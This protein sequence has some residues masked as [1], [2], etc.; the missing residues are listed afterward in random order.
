MEQ[1]QWAN[2]CCNPNL[3]IYIRK[4]SV[5]KK[6]LVTKKKIKDA[7]VNA[8]LPSTKIDDGCEIIEKNFMQV[9]I[10]VRK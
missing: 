1:V 3:D 5:V 7:A 10:A 4:T 6:K 9:Q 2:V 8:L